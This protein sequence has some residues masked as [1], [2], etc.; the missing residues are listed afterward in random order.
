[1]SRNRTPLIAAIT[2]LVFVLTS[3][4][5]NEAKSDVM[6]PGVAIAGFDVGGLGRSKAESQLRR[7]LKSS[8]GNPI[9]VRQ[10]NRVARLT[11]A[12]AKLTVDVSGMVQEALDRSNRGFFMTNAAK[13][14]V[15]V[16]REISVDSR[17]D[18]S[19]G[20]VDR[21]V[22]RTKRRFDRP[23]RDA[24]LDLSATG[25]S[26]VAS[27]NG[28]SVR[29][30]ELRRLITAALNDPNKSRTL[31]APLKTLKPSVTKSE[32]ADKYPTVVAIDRSNFKLRLFKKLKLAK[33]YRIAV[34]QS[35]LETPP[36]RYVIHNKRVNPAWNVPNSDWA[37]AL[38]GKTIPAGDPRN[39]LRAR[40]LGVNSSVGIHGTSAT[41]SIGSAA[42]HGCIRMIPADVI[43]LYDRVPVGSPVFI[44]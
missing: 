37:G 20:A 43:D 8:L 24:A 29:T 39:P 32:L 12:R 26:K 44:G 2:L 40:W 35:G 1:M 22:R 14:I 23:A 9:R 5:F 36:G 17:V 34:G 7:E 27:K 41:G 31:D 19:E 3:F 25:I 38:A 13:R 42:S 18:F 30:R 28:I 15:G 33:T 11:P 16:K 6:P 21:F 4:A 10:G